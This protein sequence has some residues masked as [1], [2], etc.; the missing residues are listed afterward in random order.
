MRNSWDAKISLTKLRN[1]ADKFIGRE[2]DLI[3]ILDWYEKFNEK[4]PCNAMG[5]IA[6]EL[7]VTIEND[8]REFTN[9]FR[10]KYS[11]DV[12]NNICEFYFIWR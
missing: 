2:A 8:I 5:V 9:K 1:D 10:I 3:S 7:T 12:D 11:H 6:S 4:E